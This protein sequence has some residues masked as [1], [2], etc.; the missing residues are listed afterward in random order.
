M[1]L[2]RGCLLVTFLTVVL[3]RAASTQSRADESVN[4]TN[5][6]PAN[7][8]P[9]SPVEFGEALDV[10]AAVFVESVSDPRPETMVT[11]KL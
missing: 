8:E 1:G 9:R 5:D 3:F 7:T 10:Y 6:A 2:L 11:W 4:A